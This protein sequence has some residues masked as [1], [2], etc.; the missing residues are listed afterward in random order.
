MEKE[1]IC[2][3]C[4]GNSE[5]CYDSGKD[6]INFKFTTEPL[7]IITSIRVNEGSIKECTI[8]KFNKK[9]GKTTKF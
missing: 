3:L 8:Y 2:G 1:N 6:R 9:Y 5:V 7:P 4:L